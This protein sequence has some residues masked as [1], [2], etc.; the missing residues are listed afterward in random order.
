M[1]DAVDAAGVDAVVGDLSQRVEYKLLDLAGVGFFDVLQAG[2]EDRLLVVVLEAAAVS[3][4]GA[5]LR[6]DQGLPERCAGVAEEHL[7]QH[8]HGQQAE[9]VAALDGDPRHQGLRL[10][11]EVVAGW[12][13]VWLDE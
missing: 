8:P 2:T 4:G 11:R 5:E 12:R 13:R 1:D 6:I 3:H 10:A 9:R 7:R